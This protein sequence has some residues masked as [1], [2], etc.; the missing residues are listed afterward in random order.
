MSQQILVRVTVSPFL[1]C[2]CHNGKGFTN[3]HREKNIPLLSSCDD[4]KLY[5]QQ[6]GRNYVNSVLIFGS[7]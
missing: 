6:V 1:V 4:K 7:N 2:E 3:K 5:M